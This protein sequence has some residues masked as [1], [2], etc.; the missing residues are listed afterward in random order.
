MTIDSIDAMREAGRRLL[1]AR[2]AGGDRQGRTSDRRGGGRRPDH[3]E[4]RSGHCGPSGSTCDT[5]TARAARLRRRWPRGSRAATASRT[6]RAGQGLRHRRDA[7]RAWRSAAGISR[8]ATSGKGSGGTRVR[9]RVQAA[10][11]MSWRRGSRLSRKPPIATME[12]RVHAAHADHDRR[13]RSRGARAR[14]REPP[15]PAR[16]RRFLGLVRDHNQGRRVTHL[17]YEAYE[18]LAVRALDRIVDESRER[19]PAVSLAIHHRIGRLEDRRG[20]RRDR[21]RL[22]ASRA[23]RSRPAATPSSASS[24]SCRSGSTST[25]RA[26]TSGSKGPPRIPTTRRRARRR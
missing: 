23:T 3:G 17:I 7:S 2:A 16:S 4:R 6:R 20:E 10:E 24:R 21:R 18:P 12:A 26:A 25:S 15:A 11:V 19:W 1:E 9:F 14:G 5:R 13:A 22:A 8:W